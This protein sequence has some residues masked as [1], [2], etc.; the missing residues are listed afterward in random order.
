VHKTPKQNRLKVIALAA[1]LAFSPLMANAAGL[2]RIT[3]LSALGQ[4]L[5]AELEITANKD[6]L[7]SLSARL[8]SA[9]AFRIAGIEYVTALTTVHFSREVKERNG[10]RFLEITSDRPVNEPFI[11]MLIELNWSSGRLVREYTFLL[12][13]PD[14]AQKVQ[15]VPVVAPAIKS[16]VPPAM[17][18]ESSPVRSAPLVPTPPARVTKPAEAPV[19]AAPAPRKAVPEQASGM[20]TDEASSRKI[21]SGD[22][23][24]KIA[25]E[26]RPDGVSL[27]QMLLALFRSNAD[28]F[29]GNMNRMRAGRILKVPDA[30]TVRAIDAA[31]AHREVV[32]QSADFN[33][34]RRKLAELA[35]SAPASSEPGSRVAAGKITPKVV[36]KAPVEIAGKDK[37]EVSRT[38][39]AAV[40]PDAKGTGKQAPLQGRLSA[41]EEDLVSRERALNEAGS[42]IAQLEKNLV[43]LKKLAE[44]KSEAGAA[45]QKQADAAK[46]PVPAPAPPVSPPPPVQPPAALPAPVSAPA[47]DVAPPKPAAEP[48]KP[49]AEVAK[50]PPSAPKK[51]VLPPPEPVPEPDFLEENAPLVFGGG[52]VLALLLGYLGFSA[53]K[54]KKK[55]VVED[56]APLSQADLSTNSVFADAASESV[57]VTAAAPGEFSISESTIDSG[58]EVVD[59]L[60]EADTYLAFG[61]DAQAEEILLDALQKEPTRH[62]IHLKLLEIYSARRS[63]MQFNTLAREL[64]DQTGGQ[65]VDWDRAQAMGHALDPNNPLYQATEQLY[66]S[67]SPAD[68][69]LTVAESAA[70]ASVA[71][72]AAVAVTQ[73]AQS[74]SNAVDPDATM[75]FAAPLNIE[76]LPASSES[77]PVVAEDIAS[78][79]FD[80][81]LG[82]TSAEK[83]EVTSPDAPVKASVD[84]G[85]DFDLDLDEPASIL[86][87]KTS[88]EVATSDIAALDIDFDLN[89]P[90]VAAAPESGSQD[91]NTITFDLDLPTESQTLALDND[92]DTPVVETAAVLANEVSALPVEADA[93]NID[94]ALD[95]EL[96]EVSQVTE[97]ISNKLTLEAVADEPALDAPK[98]DDAASID[99]DFDLDLGDSVPPI[100]LADVADGT[101][102]T[103]AESVTELPEPQSFAPP[104]DL[105]SISLELDAPDL[106]PAPESVASAD[107]VEDA[108][109]DNPESATKLELAL[110]Y[111]EMGDSDGARELL[112]EVLK[113][114]SPGQREAAQAKLATLG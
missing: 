26:T 92:I 108:V 110:A 98:V 63:P 106:A 84:S 51:K 20:A 6:E 18:S 4:P 87:A 105:G 86:D 3:V 90:D 72:V 73:E 57:N 5:R 10:K 101:L 88:A 53:Y 89:M 35:S 42:R 62:A 99:F 66:V 48:A 69:V 91:S 58:A 77:V 22:T 1:T 80:L 68:P 2:G 50:A 81:D 67:D 109:P 33:A 71:T 45:M 47:A 43:D 55:Q 21:N 41:L 107:V 59:P 103:V 52:G 70:F 31:D 23:L 64:H 8:A 25:Q 39:T 36:D 82:E 28:A 24:G 19:K 7:S 79:D 54:R 15:P 96:P 112:E 102:D 37:L 95:L 61:R 111:E 14:L 13:P 38:E 97:A 83:T 85:L 9:E 40:K 60:V 114:G 11:D 12:D 74:H 65:G 30:S 104:L 49:A 93:N 32:A 27:D 113:E 78:L 44:M 94:F 16:T 17:E 34:Y 100:D 76:T 46:P 29:D 56:T 75:V